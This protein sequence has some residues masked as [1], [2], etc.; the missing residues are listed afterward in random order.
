MRTPA[1]KKCAPGMRRHAVSCSLKTCGFKAAGRAGMGR[2]RLPLPA[3]L[4]RLLGWSAGTR[5]SFKTASGGV[6]LSV[7][8]VTSAVRSVPPRKRKAADRVLFERRWQQTL[9]AM[10]RHPQQKRWISDLPRKRAP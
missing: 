2:L 7:L 8:Q 10:R 5:L 4:L 6:M 3:L 1:I 9:Q